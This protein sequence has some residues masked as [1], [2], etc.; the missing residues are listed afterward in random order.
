VAIKRVGHDWNNREQSASGVVHANWRIEVKTF[1]HSG[2]EKILH[3]TSLNCP[4]LSIVNRDP[5]C[6]FCRIIQV[7]PTKTYLL[8]DYS[9]L[10]QRI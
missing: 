1:D 8:G 6:I 4:V 9:S 5:R 10:E 3:A 7:N 2:E